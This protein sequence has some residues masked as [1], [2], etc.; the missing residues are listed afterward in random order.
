M[1][2]IKPLSW[3]HRYWRIRFSRYQISP[4]KI[5][6][7]YS[8]RYP[9]LSSKVARLCPRRQLRRARKMW[10]ECFNS[11]IAV[12]TASRPETARDLLACVALIIRIAKQFPGRC[13]FNY[14][15]AY[16]LETAASNSKNWSQIHADLYHYHISVAV[17]A[18]QPQASRNRAPRGN[19]NS[20]I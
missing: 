8:L 7:P 14:D 9:P 1:A 20:M 6:G 19:H 13:L 16:R 5:R 11:Y 17:K 4:Q 12:I 3:G 2:S 15:R 18:T 10:V